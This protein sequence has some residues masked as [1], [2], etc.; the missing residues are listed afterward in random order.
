MKKF[1]ANFPR[2]WCV[3][4]SIIIVLVL[5]VFFPLYYLYHFCS[6]FKRILH[7]LWQDLRGVFSTPW[8]LARGEFKLPLKDIANTWKRA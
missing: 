2:T 8:R 3:T 1:K 7:N 4:V 6:N 5:L